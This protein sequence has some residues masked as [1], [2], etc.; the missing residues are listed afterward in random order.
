MYIYIYIYIYICNAVFKANV[1][2]ISYLNTNIPVVSH[3]I[4]S[5]CYIIFNNNIFAISYLIIKYLL[6]Q[7]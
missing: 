5:I 7:I 6:H 3:S 4:N 2:L 1:S